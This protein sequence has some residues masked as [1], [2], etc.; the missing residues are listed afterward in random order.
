VHFAAPAV[1]DGPVA[2]EQSA[3]TTDYTPSRNNDSRPRFLGH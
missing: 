3:S 2:A 1:G